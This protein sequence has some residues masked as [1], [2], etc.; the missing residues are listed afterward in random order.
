MINIVAGIVIDK[1]GDLRE[2]LDEFNEDLENYCFI[3]GID[4]ETLDKASNMLKGFE[5]HIKV[6]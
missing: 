6:N 4:R 2:T 5:S 3:C 1:F